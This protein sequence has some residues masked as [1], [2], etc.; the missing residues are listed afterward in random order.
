MSKLMVKTFFDQPKNSDLKTYENRNIKKI[1][2]WL[3]NV[4]NR[5]SKFRSKNRIEINDQSWKVYN[6]SSN[7]TFKTTALKSSLCNYS[8]AYLLKEQ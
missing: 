1:I 3:N 2:N 6:T 4:P 5:L 8:D 7:I